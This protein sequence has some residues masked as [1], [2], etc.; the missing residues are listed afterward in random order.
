MDYRRY[1]LRWT[2]QKTIQDLEITG[3]INI[4]RRIRLK[5]GPNSG[6]ALSIG[7]LGGLKFVM[8]IEL[9]EDVDY[10]RTTDKIMQ[11]GWLM[12]LMP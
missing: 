5:F 10:V 2:F 7:E 12:P 11:R 3:I 4:H 6:V 1:S 9:K 8:N